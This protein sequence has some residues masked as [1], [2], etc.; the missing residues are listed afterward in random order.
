M[1][2]IEIRKGRKN[3]SKSN[4]NK[5]ATNSALAFYLLH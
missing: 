5:K 2:F 3:E 1:L 4:P